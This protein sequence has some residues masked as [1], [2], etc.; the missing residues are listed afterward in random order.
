[1]NST[2]IPPEVASVPI[3]QLFTQIN[4]TTCA[5]L[6]MILGR[7]YKALRQGGGLKGLYQGIMFGTNIP[8]PVAKDYASELS[9]KKPIEPIQQ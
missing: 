4:L 7:V 3:K 5:L 8:S 9:A 6:A 2:D 1:M